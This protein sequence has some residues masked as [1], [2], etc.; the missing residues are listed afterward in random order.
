MRGLGNRHQHIGALF[1]CRCFTD[2]M[3]AVRDQ[4]VFEFQ[5]GV[6]QRSNR[7]VTVLIPGRLALGQFQLARLRLYQ[8]G[9]FGFFMIII[10]AE[11][12]PARQRGFQVRQSPVHTGLCDRRRQVGHQGRLRAALGDR[13]F[14]GIVR[15]V[16]IHVRQIS[17]QPI[18]PA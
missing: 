12:A 10:R 16:Q 15:R 4:R 14:R 5:Y 9:E 6:I 2:D 3:Q 11:C 1:S 7:G 18:W 13:A 8:R 17:D